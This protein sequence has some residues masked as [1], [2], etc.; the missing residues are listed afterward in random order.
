ME[1][2]DLFLIGDVSVNGNKEEL[3]G[4]FV[5]HHSSLGEGHEG[6]LGLILFVRLLELQLEF[7]K[8]VLSGTHTLWQVCPNCLVK[9]VVYPCASGFVSH[10]QEY[11][12]NFV[13][14]SLVPV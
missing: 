5:H 4:V 9:K 11:Q 12:G 2:W 10:A 14:I 6:T 1:I 13:I 7:G 3:V 8:E